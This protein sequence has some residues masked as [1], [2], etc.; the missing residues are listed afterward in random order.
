MIEG[1]VAGWCVCLPS[2]WGTGRGEKRQRRRSLRRVA[3]GGE[4]NFSHGGNLF[5]FPLSLSLFF[6]ESGHSQEG[7]GREGV[8]LWEDFASDCLSAFRQKQQHQI[9]KSFLL[10]QVLTRTWRLRNNWIPKALPLWSITEPIEPD[11]PPPFTKQPCYYGVVTPNGDWHP[12]L[13]VPCTNSKM[14]FYA[15]LF[16][17]PPP[18]LKPHLTAH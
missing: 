4:S 13:V 17:L 15:I 18:P 16:Y 9:E 5:C 10:H 7:Q 1:T 2:S 6:C 11:L 3:S 14:Q 8:W 12:N